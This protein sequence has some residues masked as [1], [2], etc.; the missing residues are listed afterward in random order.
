MIIPQSES[1]LNRYFI[2]RVY[3]EANKERIY[4]RMKKYR[5]KNKDILLKQVK[6]YA[7][8]HRDQ[9]KAVHKKWLAENKEDQRIKMAKYRSEHRAE[10]AEKQRNYYESNKDIAQAAARRWKEE[11]KAAGY[12]FLK[13]PVDGKRKWI[14]VGNWEAYREAHKADRKAYLAKNKDKIN[15]QRK[16]NRDAKIAAGYRRRIDP[17]TKKEVWVYVGK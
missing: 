6:E 8:E 3:R 10:L 7:N 16:A 9:R 15:A 12:R 4:S 11:K 1:Q 2:H 17:V 5:E 14:F 13:D